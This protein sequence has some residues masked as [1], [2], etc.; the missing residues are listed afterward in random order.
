MTDFVDETKKR[1]TAS[2]IVEEGMLKGHSPDQIETEMK[3][4]GIEGEVAKIRKEIKRKWMLHDA[5]WT[6]RY[7]ESR[8][9][10]IRR[11]ELQM[12]RLHEILVALG[13]IDPD[14]K[15]VRTRLAVE[16]ALAEA[17]KAARD[18]AREP[19]AKGFLRAVQSATGAD[20][21]ASALESRLEEIKTVKAGDDKTNA[22]RVKKIIET[23]DV[24]KPL[25]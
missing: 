1:L 9:L 10:A 17:A 5:D 23:E 8:N 16:K 14:D 12:T 18:Y 21:G 3:R 4:H 19:D 24:E 13:P 6:D 2:V 20:L 15:A 7:D 11:T 22:G 25:I